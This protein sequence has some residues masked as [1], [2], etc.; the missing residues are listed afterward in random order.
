MQ[1]RAQFY[2]QRLSRRVSSCNPAPGPA[3]QCALA[4]YSA[5][6]RWATIPARWRMRYKSLRLVVNLFASIFPAQFL[7]HTLNGPVIKSMRAHNLNDTYCAYKSHLWTELAAAAAHTQILRR[8][9]STVNLLQYA[10]RR[11]ITMLLC[12]ITRTHT[13]PRPFACEESINLQMSNSSKS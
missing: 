11:K 5:G 6:A 9:Q 7:H 1:S 3:R 8:Q 4:F 2:L 10:Y 13:R 12:G